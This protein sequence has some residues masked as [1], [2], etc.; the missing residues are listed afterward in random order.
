LTRKRSMLRARTPVMDSKKLAMLR[1]SHAQARSH[2]Y[3]LY[4]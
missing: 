4:R 1:G 2:R 3:L